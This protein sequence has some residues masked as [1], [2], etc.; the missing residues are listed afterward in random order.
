[1]LSPPD[2]PDPD[3]DEVTGAFG[4][5]VGP[6]DCAPDQQHVEPESGR[7]GASERG[8]VERVSE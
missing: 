2:Y 8:G 3:L 6:C 4:V 5:R 7:E 1:M